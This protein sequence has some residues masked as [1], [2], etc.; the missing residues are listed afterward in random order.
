MIEHPYFDIVKKLPKIGLS[1]K[2]AKRRGKGKTLPA[3]NLRVP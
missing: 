2:L 1:K 3:N